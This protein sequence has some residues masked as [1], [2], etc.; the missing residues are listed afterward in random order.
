MTLESRIRKLLLH[1][2]SD[3]LMIAIGHNQI[4]QRVLPSLLVEIRVHITIITAEDRPKVVV[5]IIEGIN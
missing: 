2:W 1:H 3:V 4:I 5:G